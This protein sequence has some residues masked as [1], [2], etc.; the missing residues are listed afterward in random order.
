MTIDPRFGLT[1]RTW[2][3]VIQTPIS[4]TG[5]KVTVATTA[6]I[7]VKQDATLSKP[8]Q[9]SLDFEVKRV[10]NRTELLLGNKGQGQPAVSGISQFDGGTLIINEQSRNKLGDS[11]ILRAVYEEEPTIA[12]RTVMVD[13]FGEK[14]SDV[15]PLPVSIDGDINVGEVTV[16]LTHL[17]NVPNPGD[18]ADS[19]RIGDGID[20]LQINTDG[21]INVVDVVGN[22][23][24]DAINTQ[25]ATGTLKV[26]DDQTQVLLNSLLSQ[27]E[28][29]GI[30]IGTEDGTPTGVQ[31]VFV[32]NLKSMILASHDRIR[33]VAYL[34]MA[35]KKNRRVEKFEFTSATFPGITLVR[36]FNYDLVGTEYVFVNDN[37]NLI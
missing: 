5:W 1:E 9:E 12:I 6:G 34:D 18:I 23:L 33:D 10:L 30:I 16:K 13:Q 14:Y 29:G 4:I 27:L 36:E 19:I 11:P 35:S 28:S 24:L 37:W 31:H 26:D 7:K 21:S 17:D 3:S 22:T 2:P 15:N 20:L 25:L 32:N 8:G